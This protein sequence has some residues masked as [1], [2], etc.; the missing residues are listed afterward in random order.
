MDPVGFEPT[1]FSLQTR[2]AAAAPWAQEYF[3]YFL[4]L[5]KPPLGGFPLTHNQVANRRAKNGVFSL[6]S[7]QL[8]Y[9]FSLEKPPKYLT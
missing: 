7:S 1:T 5:K 6:K 3:F 2:R 4:Q 8:D 9:S